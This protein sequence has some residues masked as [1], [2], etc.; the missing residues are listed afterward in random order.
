MGMYTLE[1][2]IRSALMS[3][4]DVKCLLQNSDYKPVPFQ[5]IKPVKERI[6]EAMMF[7]GQIPDKELHTMVSAI[8]GSARDCGDNSLDE[9]LQPIL[10]E[11]ST[12]GLS[13]IPLIQATVANHFNI[14]VV[15]MISKRRSRRVIYPR[16]IAMYLSHVLTP[17][18]SGYIGARFCR[19]HT[20]TLHAI[21]KIEGLIASDAEFAKE[22]ETLKRMVIG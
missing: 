7:R 12:P 22:I 20:T 4:Y 14:A 5:P 17:H 18:S 19:D 8:Y 13:K 2:A 1:T 16:Q 9:P 6:A 21:R 3:L 15:E 10:P 11:P